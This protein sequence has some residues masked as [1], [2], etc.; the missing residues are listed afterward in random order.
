MKRADQI[1][2]NTDEYGKTVIDYM[3]EFKNYKLLKYL[4]S[5]NVIWFVDEEAEYG[6]YFFAGTSIERKP[7]KNV[8]SELTVGAWTRTN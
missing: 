6:L 1:F 4:I 3:F 5:K 2:Y 8:S 7:I